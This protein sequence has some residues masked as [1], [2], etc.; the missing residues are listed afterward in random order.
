MLASS[1][2]GTEI[3]DATEALKVAGDVALGLEREPGVRVAIEGPPGS[4]RT[5]LVDRIAESLAERAVVV[6]VPPSQDADVPL[7]ALLQTAKPSAAAVLLAA[8]GQAPFDVRVRDVLYQLAG[9]GLALVLHF[10]DEV[11]V[12]ARDDEQVTKRWFETFVRAAVACEGLGFALVAPEGTVRSLHMTASFKVLPRLRPPSARP[13]ALTETAEW[14][15]FAEAA[16]RLSS[17]STKHGPLGPVQVRLMVGLVALGVP[18][19]EVL[20]KVSGQAT[21]DVERLVRLYAALLNT[22]ERDDLRHAVRRLLLARSSLPT[23]TALDIVAAPP[24]TEPLFTACLGY[25]NASLRVPPAVRTSLLKNLR[26]DADEEEAV[27]QRIARYH[28]NLDGATNPL[29]ASKGSNGTLVHWLEKVHH[30]AHAGALGKAEWERQRLESREF[31]IDRA[32]SLSLEARD[33]A[34]AAE[35]YERCIALRADDAYAFHYRGYNLDKL[36]TD[37][38]EVERCYREARRLDPRNLFHNSRLVTFYIERARYRDAQTA[39]EESLEHLDA[40]DPS[41]VFWH[42]TMHIVKAWLEAGEVR[43]ARDAMD[44][45]PLDL[46]DARADNLRQAIEDAEEAERLGIAVYPSDVPMAKRWVAPRLAQA[47]HE[48]RSLEAWYPGRVALAEDES[49]RVIVTCVVPVEERVLAQTFETKAWRELGGEVPGDQP[50]FVELAVY[51]GLERWVV[52]TDPQSNAAA[53]ER[54]EDRHPLRYLMGRK[55]EGSVLG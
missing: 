21:W 20:R 11:R 37:A 4:G 5:M 46:L 22:S 50:L 49:D 54:T 12:S 7:H 9:A 39:F 14:G 8:R 3:F 43:R 26:S 27:H 35:L 38:A 55:V 44:T 19:H 30:L 24:G 34:G 47:E 42:N 48:G 23:E 40:R 6:R 36:G 18:A 53:A 29:D 10:P 16:Q 31:L 33:Y 32:R 13:G 2:V 41:E 51:P 25:G 1:A 45:V 15:A 52:F 28:A 17:A